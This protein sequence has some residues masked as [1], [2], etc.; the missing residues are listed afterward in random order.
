MLKLGTENLRPEASPFPTMPTSPLIVTCAAGRVCVWEVRLE[1]EICGRE[2][3]AAG[4]AAA[5]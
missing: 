2:R 5:P 1:K 4:Q 3:H